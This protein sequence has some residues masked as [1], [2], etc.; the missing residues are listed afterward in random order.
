MKTKKGDKVTNLEWFAAECQAEQWFVDHNFK[1]KRAPI[2]NKGWDLLV[3]EHLRVN[4]KFAGGMTR[5]HDKLEFFL[6][7]ANKTCGTDY[8]LFTFARKFNGTQMCRY[9]VPAAIMLDTT[10]L[11]TDRHELPTW[12]SKYKLTEQACQLLFDIECTGL[13][14]APE[15]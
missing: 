7:Y 6:H 10:L 1:C 15:L 9:L 13:K 4:V 14:E 2:G 12:L 8:F 5:D 3:N 11:K